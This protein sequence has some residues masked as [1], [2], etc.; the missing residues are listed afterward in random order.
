MNNAAKTT[1]TLTFND[2]CEFLSGTEQEQL[3]QLEELFADNRID[4]R[5]FR[6]CEQ[7]IARDSPEV[8]PT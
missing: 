5:T 6:V 7:M 8:D 1:K 4:R 3:G 2:V